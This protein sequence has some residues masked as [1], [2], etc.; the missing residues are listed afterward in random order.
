MPP[1]RSWAEVRWRQFRHAPRPVVRAVAASLIVAVVLAVAYLVY[2]VALTRG[3][4]LPGGDLRTLAIAAL[5][6]PR[7]GHRQRRHVPRRAPADGLRNG[8]P[9]QSAGARP[10][11]SSR[12]FRSPTSSW[13]SRSRS[14]GRSWADGRESGIVGDGIA[15]LLDAL[16]IT[17]GLFV[18]FAVRSAGNHHRRGSGHPG[19]VAISEVAA[20]PSTNS[21]SRCPSCTAPPPT[22]VRRR[23]RGRGAAVRS[24][25]AADRGRSRPTRSGFRAELPARA[26]APGG[27][28][29]GRI[30]QAIRPPERG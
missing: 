9:T 8:R 17:T 5:R 29:L 10:S 28:H 19:R 12:R 23:R 20:C 24:R 7:P 4:D 11:A 3:V 13:S 14:S 1:R 15:P 2:D 18:P 16:A 22:R 25:R 27:V 26:Y 6:R 30:G 21:T